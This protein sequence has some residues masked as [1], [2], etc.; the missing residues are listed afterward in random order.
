MR[1]AEPGTYYGGGGGGGGGDYIDNPA[2]Q[3]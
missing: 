3:D 1:V 2:H